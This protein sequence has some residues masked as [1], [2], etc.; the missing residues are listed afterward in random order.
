[1]AALQGELL[2]ENVEPVV[3]PLELVRSERPPAAEPPGA[4]A[5]A[6]VPWTPVSPFIVAEIES[7]PADPVAELVAESVAEPAIERVT[8]RA[9]E[10]AVERAVV[11]AAEPVPAPDGVAELV[12]LAGELGALGRYDDA[13]RELRRAQR[14]APLDPGVR[15]SLGI[16]AFRRGLYGQAEIEL[17]WVCA[18]DSGHGTAHFYRGE[19]LNRLGRVDEALAMLER[20][21]TLQ[22]DNY[23]AYYLMG[24]LFD[25]KNLREE[26]AAMY[27]RARELQPR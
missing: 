2:A 3:P 7:E 13:E 21:A 18:H 8:P 11:R 1:M 27:R 14:I 22:P 10:P 9:A 6:L 16:L 24:I 15:A 12:A 19:A 23:R 4:A 5:T 17:G 25:R 20:A 26:A